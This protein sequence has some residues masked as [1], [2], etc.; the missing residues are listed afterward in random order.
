[1]IPLLVLAV[2]ASVPNPAD[3]LVRALENRYNRMKTLQATF[4]QVYKADMTGPARQE[5]G[6]VYMKKPGKMRWEYARP[7]VKLFVSDGKTIYFYVPQD[8]QVTRIPVKESDDLRTP[9]AFLLGRMNLK[10]AFRVE[11]ANDAAPIDPGNPVLRLTPK[12]EGERFREL[13]LEVE[14]G[15]H[16]RR[17]RVTEADGGMTEF[18]L[19]GEAGNVTLDD[20]MFR[21]QPPP[22]VEVIEEKR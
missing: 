19:S 5:A 15:D 22:G 4:V 21:F 18:R 16:V 13:L 1:V 3:S 8:A 2:A 20:S 11:L 17:V 10:R 12:R 9:L 7:E 6:T 14:K